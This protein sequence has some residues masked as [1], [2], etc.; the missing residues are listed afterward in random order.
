M[1]VGFICIS[2]TLLDYLLLLYLSGLIGLITLI[3]LYVSIFKPFI[4]LYVLDL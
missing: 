4:T 3:A 2:S 1:F